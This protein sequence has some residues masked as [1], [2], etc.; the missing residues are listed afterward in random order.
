MAWT[1]ALALKA[2]PSFD[3]LLLRL[4][5]RFTFYI[6]IRLLSHGHTKIYEYG[7]KSDKMVYSYLSFL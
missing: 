2:P 5:Q 6:D 4:H 7:S 3:R 1:F